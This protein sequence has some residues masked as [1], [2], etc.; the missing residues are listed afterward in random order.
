[1]DLFNSYGR[2]RN[3]NAAL[4]GQHEYSVPCTFVMC[5][6][7]WEQNYY[8]CLYNLVVIY[9]LTTTCSCEN[10]PTVATMKRLVW[11]CILFLSIA[12]INIQAKQGKT[13]IFCEICRFCVILF[14][15]DSNVFSVFQQCCL[16]MF[17]TF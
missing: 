11:L 8:Q 5:G 1:M 4:V 14:R 10:K 2:C 7:G 16:R 17:T 15:G 3:Y 9:S 12:V 6:R 13:N